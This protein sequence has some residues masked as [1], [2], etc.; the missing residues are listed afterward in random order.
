MMM[1]PNKKN[2][3]SIIVGKI[4]K[5]EDSEAPKMEQE[6]MSEGPEQDYNLAMEDAAKKLMDSVQSKDAKMFLKHLT[7]LL[8]MKEQMHESSEEKES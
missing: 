5:P 3:L 1:L 2:A 8:D 7:D 6:E 4:K